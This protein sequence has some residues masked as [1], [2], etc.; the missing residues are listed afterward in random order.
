MTEKIKAS[1]SAVALGYFDGIHFGHRAVLQKA[2][3]F[4]E[5]ND[6]VPVVLLFDIHPRKLLSDNVPPML[7]SEEKKRE[8][9]LQM[10]FTVADFDFRKGMN[11]TPEEFAEKVLVEGLNVKAVSCG[12]DYR[13]GKGGKGNADTL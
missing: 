10:G 12:Y 7:M 5:K 2:L 13:Y 8:K 3:S 1:G 11:Y 9:L 6:L 4:A